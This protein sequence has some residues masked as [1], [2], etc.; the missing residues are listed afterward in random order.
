MSS[1]QYTPIDPIITLNDGDPDLFPIRIDILDLIRRTYR[2]YN[3]PPPSDFPP[4]EQVSGYGMA[5]ED[6][7][8]EREVIPESLVH[9][10]QRIRLSKKKDKKM[11]AIKLELTTIGDFWEAIESNPERYAKEIEWLKQM[12]RYRLLGKFFFVNGKVH[13]MPGWYWFFLNF[14][15]L[16]DVRPEYRYWDNLMAIGWKFASLDTTTFANIDPDTRKPIANA[17]GTYDMIDVGHRVCL[18][19]NDPKSRRVGDT[20]KAQCYGM[21]EALRSYEYHFGT[22]GKDEPHAKKVF[23]QQFVRP[24]EKM[25]IFFKPVWDSILGVKPKE[26]MLFDGD[27]ANFGL[28]TRITHATSANAENYNGDKLHFYHRDEAGNCNTLETNVLMFDGRVK[29]VGDVMVGDLLMGADGTPRKVL[30]RYI[31]Y[32]K[33]YKVIPKKGDPWRCNE[34]HILT[35]KMSATRSVNYV[36]GDIK[37]ISVIDYLSQGKAMKKS[38]VLYRVGVDFPENSHLIDPYMIGIWLGDG[39]KHDISIETPDKEVSEYLNG[40]SD[41]FN[42][43]IHKRTQ[44]VKELGRDSKSS[45][46]RISGSVRT[47]V[48]L[49]KDGKLAY[50][51]DSCKSAAKYLGVSGTNVSVCSLGKVKTIKGFEIKKSISNN[52]NVIFKEFKRLGLIKNKHIPDEYLYDSEQNRLQLLAGIIDSDGSADNDRNKYVYEI[53]QVNSDLAN[54]IVFLAR[55]LG[56]SCSIT[57]KPFKSNILNR[58]VCKGVTN[59]INIYGRDLYRIPC[60]VERKRIIEQTYSENSKARTPIHTG[61]DIVP[62]GEDYYCGFKLDGDKRYLLD[63]FTVIHNTENEDINK[64]HSIVQFCLTLGGTIKGFSAYT[65]TVEEVASGSAGENYM[66]LCMDSHYEIRKEDGRTVSGMYNIFIPAEYRV[67]GYIDKYGY[68]IVGKPTPEQ[69][70]FIGKDYGSAYWIESTVKELTRKKDWTKLA[71]FQRQYPRKFREA[72]SP[73]GK[74]Q[75]FPIELIRNRIQHLQFIERSLL[76]V[77][78]DF[79]WS[80]G[81]GSDVLWIPNDKGRWFLSHEFL[82]SETNRRRNHGGVWYPENPLSVAHSADVFGSDRPKGRASL[83]GLAARLLYDD[84]VDPKSKPS[85]LWK[86]DRLIITYRNRP[87]GGVDEFCEDSLKQVIYCGGLMYPERNK[88]HVEPYFRRYGYEGYLLFD[89]D[90]NGKQA[91]QSAGYYT[92]TGIKQKIFNFT[93][94]ELVKNINRERHID[95]LEEC[96]NI[97]SPEQMTDFDLFTAVGGTLLAAYNPYYQVMKRAVTYRVNTRGFIPEEVY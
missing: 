88:D 78:G 49:Y 15:Y 57:K 6:Q 93:Q 62:D 42:L 75:F 65:T 96:M 56:F 95:W 69:E 31:G 26:N 61:F 40:I 58:Y 90:H 53:T 22:Q 97:L 85:E 3:L 91:A 94:K 89:F 7:V 77:Q 52:K 83:G 20:S 64:S 36:T 12:W 4:F 18:G 29:S 84:T 86:T 34:N 48:D 73:P 55:S 71:I 72:F 67:Q 46:H 1:Y 37:N 38:M 50:S 82:P 60:K 35:V 8:F 92:Q 39:S 14:Y 54:Q 74:N 87:D 80:N 13:Y 70:R 43:N 5:P 21:E 23:Q 2:Q 10:E 63:D 41:K 27:T 44:Y 28:H 76:P 19:V 66:N 30:E 68:P 24:F 59:R 16:D 32:G 81:F 17:D 11:T 25:P 45:N 9:L 47:P 79:E 33:V 51:F